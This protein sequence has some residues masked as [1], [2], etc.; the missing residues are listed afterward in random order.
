MWLRTSAVAIAHL[1]LTVLCLTVLVTDRMIEINGVL[2]CG[3]R[4]V[5]YRGNSASF[6]DYRERCDSDW[7]DTE[8]C[9]SLPDLQRGGK[10]LM[11]ALGVSMGL[12]LTGLLE[13]VL[14]HQMVLISLRYLRQGIPLPR[15]LPPLAQA[16]SVLRWIVLLDPLFNLSGLLLWV[17]LSQVPDLC[18]HYTLTINTSFYLQITRAVISLCLTVVVVIGILE[19]RRENACLLARQATLQSRI[20]REAEKRHLD[21][22][23][24]DE[25]ASRSFAGTCA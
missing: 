12:E 4:T 20:Q 21:T 18:H 9:D 16:L 10:V 13:V 22:L 6:E 23:S 15:F 2:N 24:L 19:H 3:L 11:A 1:T 8:V 5:T 14:T 17:L 25:T 7:E